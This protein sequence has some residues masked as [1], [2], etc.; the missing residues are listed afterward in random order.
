[1]IGM[2]SEMIALLG[3]RKGI[4]FSKHLPHPSLP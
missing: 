2:T 4:T 1:M 3:L